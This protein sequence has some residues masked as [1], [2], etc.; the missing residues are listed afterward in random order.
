MANKLFEPLD[1]EQ[2]KQLHQLYQN[3]CWTKKRSLSDIQKMLCT[4]KTI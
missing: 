2:I 1:E 3:E 4:G